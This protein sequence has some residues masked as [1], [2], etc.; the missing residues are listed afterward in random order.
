MK[1][2]RVTH[3]SPVSLEKETGFHY[4]MTTKDQIQYYTYMIR[5]IEK[6]MK[7]EKKKEK[8]AMSFDFERLF[9]EIINTLHDQRNELYHQ[10]VDHHMKKCEALEI[11]LGRKKPKE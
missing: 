3:Y 2:F 1:V 9:F 8:G 4:L 11:K 5:A 7:K 10:L 6:M